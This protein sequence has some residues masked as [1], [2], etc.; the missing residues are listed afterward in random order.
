MP[1]D[2]PVL[3]LQMGIV[4]CM[5][6]RRDGD[7]LDPKYGV[8]PELAFCAAVAQCH[9]MFPARPVTSVAEV[10]RTQFGGDVPNAVGTYANSP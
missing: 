4:A 6:Q 10:Y 1:P 5:K 8:P 2:G 3:S 7:V 9:G